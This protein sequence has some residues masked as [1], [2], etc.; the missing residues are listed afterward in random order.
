MLD[1]IFRGN[2]D[3]KQAEVDL[4]DLLAEVREERA[5]MRAQ[6]DQASA[7]VTRLSRTNKALDE[8]GAKA[9]T[10]MHK[11]E[12]LTEATSGYEDRARRLEKVDGRVGEL[13]KQV[14]DAERASKALLDPDGHIHRHRKAL[15]DLG[16]QARDAHAS[17]AQLRQ[18]GQQVS[19]AQAQ[20]KHSGVELQRALEGI[21]TVRGELDGLRAVE[22]EMRQEVH[23]TRDVAR[24]AH[25]DSVA[26]S[27][28]VK[29]LATKLES[30]AQLQDLSKDTEKR[31]ASL[32]TLAEHVSLK[33]KALES[34]RQAVEQAVTETSR[35]TQMVGA[36]EAQ[37]GK[38]AEGG[39]Q[40]QRAEDAVAR[41]EQ[42]ARGATQDLVGATAARAQ[43]AQESA[44]LE[45]QGKTLLDKLR[46]TVERLAFDKA[47]FDGFA[48]RMKTLSTDLAQA[49]GRMH[50][51]LSKDEAFDAMQYKAESLAKMFSDLRTE[52]E[53]LGRR[54]SALDALTEQLG[55]VEMMSKRTTVQQESLLS[56]RDD[57]Q[58]M[59]TQ[60][61]QLQKSFADASRLRD[62]V[63]ADRGAL[64]AFVERTAAM[65]GRTPEIESR[66]SAVLSKFTLLEEGHESARR[67]SD[68]TAKLEAECDRMGGRMQ[69]IE[70]IDERVNGLFGLT[71]EV[72]RKIAD[73]VARREEIDGLAQRCDSLGAQIAFAQQ[74]IESAGALQARLVPLAADVSKLQEA[75]QAS[76][77]ALAAIKHDEVAALE[78]QSRLS[79]LIE[80]G[81]RQAAETTERL[82]QVQALG[83][84][85][86]QASARSTEVM[87]QLADVQ[88][89]QRD[90]LAQAT[91]TEEQLQR[92]EAMSRQ[93]EQ[94]RALMAHTDK[95][96]IVFEGR[97]S[98]LDRHADG[99]E[100]KI[101]SLADREALVLAVKAEVDGIRELSSRSKADLHFVAEHRDDVT[102]LRG[103]VDDLLGRLGDTDDKIVLIEGWRK[104]VEEVQASAKAVTSLLGDVQGTLEGL[105]EQR[106]VID[107]V[108]EKLARLDFT[109]QEAQSTLL[110]LDTSAQ[111]AKGTLR[112]LQREREV[113]E[114]VEKCI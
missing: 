47:E 48:E 95:T 101:Q 43:F 8:L 90:A 7:M 102:D 6:L 96:L 35:L 113:S 38:L 37:I 104:K 36:M 28:T 31:I 53:E 72:E 71:T 78:Q 105:G 15:D 109:V 11:V 22:R 51:V 10:A 99:L 62:G 52:T 82:R 81:M 65:I 32:H 55:S 112:T 86:A 98:D 59:R 106:A 77:R 1:T 91:L 75:L 57:L 50:S 111:E 18:E 61:E 114:K 3:R 13:A 74:Q 56:A 46:V 41:I 64:E 108:G 49:E 14:A 2:G 84:D 33:A 4:R 27:E 20:L 60:L 29:G 25:A 94:R 66:L 26:A 44:R 92:A 70:K 16:A 24:Q 63:A 88:M 23:G 5:A 39:D 12:Q 21:A 93:L 68:T 67:L 79:G 9:D 97:L 107:D 89:R 100:K 76:Q 85:L 30:L 42:L 103:K 19:Q 54:Q 58:A 17:L 40:M 83:T 69:F 34:Q 73:Q 45:S 80:H 87:T 110:R